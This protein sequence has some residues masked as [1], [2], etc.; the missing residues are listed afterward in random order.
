MLVGGRTYVVRRIADALHLERR[1]AV[2]AYRMELKFEVLASTSI[3]RKK[4]W[5]KFAWLSE[6]SALLYT[7]WFADTSEHNFYL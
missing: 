5:P 2:H 6:V 1:I 4:P 7:I 3:R